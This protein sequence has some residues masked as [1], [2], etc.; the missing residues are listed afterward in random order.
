MEGGQV[1]SKPDEYTRVYEAS[2]DIILRALTQVF[3]EKG[4]GN[5]S[6]TPDKKQIESDYLFQ[7]DWRSKAIAR[8]KKKN[9][10]ECEVTLSVITEK[11]TSAG[12]EMRRLLEAEQYDKLFSATELQIYQEQYK[13]KEDRSNP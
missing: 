3:K 7:S 13:L 1:I 6:I 5:S 10:K 4:F 11:K 8:V 12:W 2:E 9:W